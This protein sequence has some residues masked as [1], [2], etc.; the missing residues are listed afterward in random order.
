MQYLWMILLIG[1]VTVADQL[2][3]VWVMENIPL[4]SQVEAIPG[5]FHLT[6]VQNTGAAFS[7]F[8]GMQWLF[9]VV[10]LLF[11]LGILWEFRKNALGFTCLERWCLIAV[12]AGGLGNMI[13]RLRLGY[14]VDMIEVEFIRFPVF[15]VAD[16][17]ITC[18]SIL[19]L[20]HLILFN[21]EFWKEEKKK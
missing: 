18:G 2:S 19:L 16:C 3:K 9:V 12:F 17:F 6:Y 4:Y 13:D 5:L 10:F 8:E 11:A 20:V 15:N 7:S 14:V 1:G 21:K